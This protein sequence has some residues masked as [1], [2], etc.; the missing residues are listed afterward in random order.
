MAPTPRVLPAGKKSGLATVR[1]AQC[2]W[3]PQ[4][5]EKHPV[6][7]GNLPLE[8]MYLQGC[9]KTSFAKDRSAHNVGF[10]EERAM[11]FPRALRLL[12]TNVSQWGAPLT[13]AII[14]ICALRLHGW[15]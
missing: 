11:L 5:P 4:S 13:P 10:G 12:G 1:H 6:R 9:W 2:L 7:F 8:K 15:R 14:T 3:R